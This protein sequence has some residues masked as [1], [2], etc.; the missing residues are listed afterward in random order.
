MSDRP[1]Q[2]GDLVIVVHSHCAKAF[3]VDCGRVLTVLKIEKIF[4]MCNVCRKIYHSECAAE[5]EPG[6]WQ[7]TAW[8]RRIPPLSEPETTHHDEEAHA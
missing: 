4:L 8:L 5:V 1:I 6:G 2:V 7:P 3:A